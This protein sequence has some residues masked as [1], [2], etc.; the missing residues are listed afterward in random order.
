MAPKIQG[1]PSPQLVHEQIH[2][3]H[4]HGADA[5]KPAGMKTISQATSTQDTSQTRKASPSEVS[6]KKGGAKFD[7]TAKR[8][9]LENKF[10]K[11]KKSDDAKGVKKGTELDASEKKILTA[12]N[13]AQRQRQGSQGDHPEPAKKRPK[14]AKV[15]ACMVLNSSDKLMKKIVLKI[16]D[17]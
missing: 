2:L 3:S 15:T 7:G 8:A 10:E 16:V 9:D 17:S 11:T 14:L 5:A 13:A 4:S 6:S 12:R 1:S